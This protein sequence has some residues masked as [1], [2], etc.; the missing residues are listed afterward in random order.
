MG[1]KT[2]IGIGIPIEWH[3]RLCGLYVGEKKV[4]YREARVEDHFCRKYNGWGIQRE[5]L[6]SLRVRGCRWVCIA[7]L[8][9]KKALIAPLMDFF[10]KGTVDTLRAQDGEQ[11]FLHSS[12]FEERDIVQRTLA[13]VQPSIST[14]AQPSP[15]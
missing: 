9:Q 11:V 13:A 2:P 1:L 14:S 3:G 5:I 12:H 10:E 15:G 6:R 7:L 8:E 4:Y